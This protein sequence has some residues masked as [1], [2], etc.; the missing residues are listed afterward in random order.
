MTDSISVVIVNYN[1]ASLLSAAIASALAQDL[2]PAE[3]IVVDNG[4]DDGSAA[5]V[6]Q[7]FGDAV[8]L[9]RLDENLGFAGG[10]NAGVAVA[11]GKWIALLNNDAVADRRWLSGMVRAAADDPGAGMVACRIVV[12]NQRDLLDNVGVGLYADGMS[13]GVS[14]FQRAAAVGPARVLM[15]SG[16][17]ALVLRSAFDEAGGFDEG[18][19]CYSEDTDLFIR[20]RLL[21]YRCAVA[22]RAVVYHRGG[23]GTLGTVS[24]FKV[25][26]VERN[27]VSVLLRY[28]PSRLALTSFFFT[29]LRYAGLFW[30][31][32]ISGRGRHHDQ[33]AEV[34]SGGLGANL[35]ALVRAYRHA[36]G[37]A[38]SDLALRAQWKARRRV[39][40]Q[41][42]EEWLSR[43]RLGAKSLFTLEP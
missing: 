14:H 7:E 15:P 19:F 6:E 42:L 35:A 23:G 31:L 1:R 40:E 5:M 9:V 13:R 20:L 16:C 32:A 29:G 12:E 34:V 11:T 41:A 30:S 43:Y 37:R 38:S 18:F 10:N 33:E 2:M 26:L 39:P 4:S 24:P 22:D 17:A 3:V 36:L 8:R 28:Y 25:Y 21:G 27:R